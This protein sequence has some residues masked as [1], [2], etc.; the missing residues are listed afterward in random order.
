MCGFDAGWGRVGIGYSQCEILFALLL[1]YNSCCDGIALTGNG[2]T[3]NMPALGAGD[4][5]F[6][7]RFPDA[8]LGIHRSVFLWDGTS[9]N[10]FR[11][12]MYRPV[13]LVVVM[14]LI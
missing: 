7:S 1:C 6:E 13:G 14:P 10:P 9:H 11:A 3:A 5:G 8:Y 2:V 4:S 12:P